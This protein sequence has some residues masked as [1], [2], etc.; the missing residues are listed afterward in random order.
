MI[1][2]GALIVRD[3][4]TGAPFQYHDSAYRLDWPDSVTFCEQA[5]RYQ[6]QGYLGIAIP[7]ER[8]TLVDQLATDDLLDSAARI[9]HDEELSRILSQ[10]LL[11]ITVTP[12]TPA[13]RDA[14]WREITRHVH[15]VLAS[16]EPQ[17]HPSIA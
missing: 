4:E 12:H 3:S 14:A 13:E 8:G 6:S 1:R 11:S 10:P 9:F 15:R 16:A 7:V 5:S 2:T 17:S